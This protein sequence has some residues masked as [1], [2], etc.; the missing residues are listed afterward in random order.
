MLKRA[1]ALKRRAFAKLETATEFLGTYLGVPVSVY[2]GGPRRVYDKATDAYVPAPS[3]S[4]I[5]LGGVFGGTY[6]PLDAEH[7]DPV[8]T[9]ARIKTPFRRLPQQIAAAQEELAKL[10][11][12]AVDLEEA[13]AKPLPHTE[14]IERMRVRLDAILRMTDLDTAVNADDDAAV[15]AEDDEGAPEGEHPSTRPDFGQ[16]RFLSPL[17][18]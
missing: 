6:I 11:K 4:E 3:S 10:E 8:Q 5:K 1:E 14:E 17:P 16:P 18:E 15:A 9:M 12:A 7:P 13:I 2:N